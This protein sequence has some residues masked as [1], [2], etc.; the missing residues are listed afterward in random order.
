MPNIKV[1]LPRTSEDV[2]SLADDIILFA[3]AARGGEPPED[4]FIDWIAQYPH[5]LYLFYNDSTPMGFCRLDDRALDPSLGK[6]TV[7][8]HGA[9]LPEYRKHADTPALFVM[10]SAFKVKKTIIAKID[11][12]NL[13]ALGFCRKWGFKKINREHGKDVYRLKR[14][15][16]I[17]KFQ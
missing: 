4:D 1:V 14:N 7:A 15:D 10:R 16:F 2:Y 13:G 8:I 9:M 6:N 5:T 11:P 12:T 17:R 3:T